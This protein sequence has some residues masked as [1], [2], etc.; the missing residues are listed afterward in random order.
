LKSWQAV[1]LIIRIA[2][3]QEDFQ[4]QEPPSVQPGAAPIVV[5]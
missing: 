3:V 1:S 4:D 5:A 2:Y